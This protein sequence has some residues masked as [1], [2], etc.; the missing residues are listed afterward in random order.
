MS[1]Y[2]SVGDMV[3]GLGW[4]H[5]PYPVSLERLQAGNSDAIVMK[6]N[7]A[8]ELTPPQTPSTPTLFNKTGST[9]GFGTYVAFVP[10]KKIGLVMLANRSFSTPRG[11]PQR[12]RCSKCWPRKRGRAADRTRRMADTTWSF[13]LTGFAR[14]TV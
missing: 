4:E 10:A 5:Y 1:G 14:S 3:Q 11:S 7:A 8:T 12:M 6:P 2:F 13:S 9:A